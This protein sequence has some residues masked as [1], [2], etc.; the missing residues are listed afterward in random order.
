M[1]QALFL[2]IAT[3]LLVGCSGVGNAETNDNSEVR[4]A[5][6]NNEMILFLEEMTGKYLM[7]DKVTGDDSRYRTISEA[8]TDVRLA[9]FELEDDYDDSL[10]EVR[11]LLELGIIIEKS[12]NELFEGD[13]SSKYEDSVK[14]GE[15]LGDFSRSFLDGELPPTFKALTGIKNAND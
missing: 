4:D 10:P 14:V 3:L 2:F 13:E 6:T 1:R 9:M 12:L 5:I 15:L 8:I 7:T 11:G